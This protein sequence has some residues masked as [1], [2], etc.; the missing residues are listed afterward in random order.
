MPTLYTSLS[1]GTSTDGSHCDV[2]KIKE[3]ECVFELYGPVFY[4]LM[5]HKLDSGDYAFHKCR[6]LYKESER[7]RLK[8]ADDL[9]RECAKILGIFD[10][11]IDT[12]DNK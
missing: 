4:E 8:N 9:E 2:T 7:Q 6:Q 12:T 1:V 5:T 3:S 10:D 11:E